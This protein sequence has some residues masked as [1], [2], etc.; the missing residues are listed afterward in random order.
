MQK[1]NFKDWSRAELEDT[2]NLIQ[3]QKLA[4]LSEWTA[5][6]LPITLA[7]FEQRQLVEFRDRLLYRGDDWNEIELIEHFIAP[8]MAIVNFN[9]EEFGMF[10]GRTMTGVV[11]DYEL[12][13]EP[14]AVIAK[15]RRYPKIPYFCFHEY[16]KEAEP[17]G[18][19]AG[20][21]LVAMLVAQEL[22]GHRAPVYGLY[23]SG[24]QWYFIV[25]HHREYAISQS[26]SADRDEIFD[27]L[28][29]LK[30]LKQI[31]EQLAHAPTPH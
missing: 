17:K 15:G 19:P 13:G 5:A 8:I 3:V 29:M 31:I 16:K 26:F 30:R 9:T 11:G 22:N 24:K 14:D 27:I 20:Q 28:K 12:S 6:S 18:D 23:V 7:D 10:S 2:F 4:A 21:A 1:S 25:L